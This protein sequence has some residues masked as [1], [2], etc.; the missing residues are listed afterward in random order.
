MNDVQVRSQLR[1]GTD[2]LGAYAFMRLLGFGD[3]E[4][5]QIFAPTC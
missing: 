2:Y 5:H 4:C 3:S 1:T